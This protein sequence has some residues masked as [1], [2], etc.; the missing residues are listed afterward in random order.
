[1]I[2]DNF[3]TEVKLPKS[4][5]LSMCFLFLPFNKDY[6]VYTSYLERG[7]NPHF[8]NKG[9]GGSVDVDKRDHLHFHS[10]LHLHLRL[11]M[12]INHQTTNIS[13]K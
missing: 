13:H 9:G 3:K 12:G 4:I 8:V 5:I 10:P 2:N 7:L 1:M 11:Y 6:I